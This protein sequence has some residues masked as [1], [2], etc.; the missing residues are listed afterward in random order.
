[1]GCVLSIK[2][3]WEHIHGLTGEIGADVEDPERLKGIKASN[4]TPREE[5][6]RGY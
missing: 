1:M 3:C 2:E 6:S 4:T 5:I